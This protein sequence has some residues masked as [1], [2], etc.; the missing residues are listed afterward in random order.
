MVLTLVLAAVGAAAAPVSPADPQTES[1]QVLAAV[2]GFFEAVRTKDRERLE[3][4]VVPDGLATSLRLDAEPRMRSWHWHTYIENALGAPGVW[5]EHLIDPMVRVDRDI[6]VVWSRYE[7][8]DGDKFSHC[9]LDHFDLVRQAGQWR[10]YN[11]TWTNQTQ[12]C[13]G[14]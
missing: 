6:A 5:T 4:A 9:G 11:L 7:L 10:I 2:D 8:T 14:R 13:P 1:A 12:G 3:S